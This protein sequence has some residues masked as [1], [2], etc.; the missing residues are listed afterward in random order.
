LWRECVT[1]ALDGRFPT[2]AQCG[3][4]IAG[5]SDVRV[6]DAVIVDLN[7]DYSE[8]ADHIIAG[9][10]PDRVRNALVG[11]MADPESEP[12]G[13]RVE[14]ASDLAMRISG[15]AWT[16]RDASLAAPPLTVA[17]IAGWWRGEGTIAR[18][19]V[20]KAIEADPD[21][22]LARLVQA[23]F[24]SGLAPRRHHAWRSAE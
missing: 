12:D 6:R 8:E 3:R 24:E 1:R 13:A 9:A 10:N 20:R 14:A 7:S 21:Y 15:Y 16:R 18:K 2:D 5:L 19:V 23:T 4:I 17:A 22:Y 11:L